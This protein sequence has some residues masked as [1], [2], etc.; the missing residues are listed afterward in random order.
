MARSSKA[1]GA[2]ASLLRRALVEVAGATVALALAAGVLVHAGV[3]PVAGAALALGLFLGAVLLVG[4]HLPEHLPRRQPGPANRVTL[5]RLALVGLLAGLLAAPAGS[6]TWL[7]F[8]L[9]SS[10]LLLDG[11]DG[12][13]ARR[14]RCASAFGARFDLETDALLVLVLCALA[15]QSGQAGAWVMLSGAMRYLFA[16]VQHIWPR[17]RQPLPAS[18]RRQS[19]CVLQVVALLGV[20]CPL[21]APPVSTLV[22]AA[23][24]TLLAASF[25]ADLL[26]LRRPL[27]APLKETHIGHHC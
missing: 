8:A 22:A 26:W 11:L 25:G 21:T 14:C 24:L 16:L 20:V 1:A 5:L 15:W 13:L 23:G 18:R 27:P 7:A 12:W 2:G 6:G 19:I 10:V 4:R 3:L 17:L 9:A